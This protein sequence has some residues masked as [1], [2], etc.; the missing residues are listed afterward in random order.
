MFVI[1]S[2]RSQKIWRDSWSV[3]KD[4][5]ALEKCWI[6]KD[7]RGN[8]AQRWRIPAQWRDQGQTHVFEL[9]VER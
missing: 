9:F 7:G 5:L 4:E 1:I 6:W 2:E 3:R 8:G